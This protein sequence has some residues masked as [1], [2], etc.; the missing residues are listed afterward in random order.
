M[1]QGF[2]FFLSASYF[3]LIVLKENC[4]SNFNINLIKL[5]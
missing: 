4:T 3:L 5:I 2:F 1:N